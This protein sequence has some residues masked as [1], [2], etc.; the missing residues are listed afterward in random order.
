[1]SVHFRLAMD[2]PTVTAQEHKVMVRNGRPVFYDPQELKEA[3]ASICARL[4]KYAPQEPI[5][6]PVVLEVKWLFQIRG[7]SHTHGQ[8]RKEKP[9]TD[10]LQKMLKDCMTLFGFW[11]DDALVVREAV[12]KRWVE[13][14]PGIYVSIMTTDEYEKL[15]EALWDV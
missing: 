10:N 7:G 4:A 6:S 11:K 13:H 12:E 14:H 5:S 2:P 3:K 15:E 9:D 8:W 1:M